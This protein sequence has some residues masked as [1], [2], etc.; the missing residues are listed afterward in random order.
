[1]FTGIIECIGIVKSIEKIGISGKISV[2]T[3][4]ASDATLQAGPALQVEPALGDSIAVNGVCL[5]VTRLG[6]GEFVADVSDETFKQ[7][8]LG[9]LASGDRVNLERALTPLKPMGG[10]IVT[11][12][13]DCRGVL[14]ARVKKGTG[15][16]LEFNID[17]EFQRLLVHKGSVTVDGISLTVAALTEKGFRVAVIPHTIENTTLQKLGTGGAVNI[18][19]DII[20]K[21]VE[22]FMRL[23]K[24]E[25]PGATKRE[26]NI[27]AG[28]LAEHGFLKGE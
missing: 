27:T 16:E 26:G 7:T 10:H 8:N 25:G 11:G 1:M 24:D 19:T 5:T 4:F 13:I 18:E 23:A 9:A 3:Q 20:G 6:S 28:F 14:L 2:K 21:Y 12:H 22:R 17:Q 15:Q